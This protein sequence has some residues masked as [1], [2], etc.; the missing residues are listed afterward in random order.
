MPNEPIN[1]S[2]PF[3]MLDFAEIGF[4]SELL[5]GH[6]LF[7]HAMQRLRRHRH[8]GRVEICYLVKGVQVYEVDG[9]RYVLRGQDIFLSFPDEEHSTG[10]YPQEKGELYWLQVRLPEAEAPFLGFAP[11]V[12]A[13]VFACFRQPTH[14]AFRGNRRVRVCFEALLRAAA[15]PDGDMR[16]V[17]VSA[18]VV[19]LL[20]AVTT[21]AQAA[22]TAEGPAEINRV[23]DYIDT[24]LDERFS[25]DRLAEMLSLSTSR[26]KAKFKQ[27]VGMP[28]AE[29]I[30]RRRLDT[31]KNLLRAG[32]TV[33]DTA[34]TLGFSS[35]QYFA[36]VFKRYTY[37][38][39]S[40]FVAGQYGGG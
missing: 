38:R 10:E 9:Q 2:S 19:E 8:A 34:H 14:R 37:Q 6:Y 35:S 12:A 16:R 4:A 27:E 13:P 30:M 28:P 3:L 40:E 32:H 24:H 39:P 33:T 11:A 20:H 21:C 7:S 31:A 17:L 1:L 29:Y 18:R 5:L 25:L 26:F 23:T 15:H 22:P 36:T